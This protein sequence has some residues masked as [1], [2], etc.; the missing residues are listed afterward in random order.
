LQ[1]HLEGGMTGDLETL[2][3]CDSG[4]IWAATSLL[5]LCVIPD[6]AEPR[7]AESVIALVSCHTQIWGEE[8][9]MITMEQSIML[10][11]MGYSSVISQAF[12]D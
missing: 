5:L 1:G 3:I 2:A 9:V 11:A 12:S 6:Y 7:D 8:K 4:D 10:P